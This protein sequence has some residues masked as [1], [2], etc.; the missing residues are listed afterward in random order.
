VLFRKPIK[1]QHEAFQ[2]VTQGLEL[3]RCALGNC[4]VELLRGAFGIGLK[5][6]VV[7]RVCMVVHG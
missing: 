4:L 3:T 1:D 2:I 5:E 7:G 6:G